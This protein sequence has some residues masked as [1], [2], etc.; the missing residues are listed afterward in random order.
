MGLLRKNT[1]LEEDL[2]LLDL[3]AKSLKKRPDGRPDWLK[4][5]V[6]EAIEVALYYR[7]LYEYA[8]LENP[9]LMLET[10]TRH[11]HSA[12]HLAMGAQTGT[13]V[14]ID[15]EASAKMEVEAFDLKNIRAITSDSVLALDQV[16]ETALRAPGSA[17]DLMFIDSAHF[18][19]IASSEYRVYRPRLRHGALILC[20]DI[21]INPDM[22][23]FWASIEDPKVEMNFLH[24]MGFGIALKDSFRDYRG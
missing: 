10:G 13:V 20:D 6:D 19:P 9:S 7:F 12:A 8:K 22:E 11:G 5:E 24:Y 15:I 1:S 4:N 18:Y 2:E 17:F 21:H 14:T 23:R 16:V 3:F